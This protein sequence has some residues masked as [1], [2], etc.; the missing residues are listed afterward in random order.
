MGWTKREFITQAFEE[1]GLAA[2]V[3]DITPEQRWSALRR[4]DAMMAQWNAAGVRVGWG[5][6]SKP[7]M[8]DIDEQTNVTDSANEAI[9]TNLAIRLA[10]GFG[11]TISPDLKALAF[12]SYANL[13][14]HLANKIPQR[15]YPSSTPIGA[16]NKNLNAPFAMPTIDEL[17]AG[18]D[19]N[20]ILE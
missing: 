6:P 15:Q 10:S 11:K 14:S 9:Y 17:Q 8:S 12:T 16:G 18:D 5:L 4:L 20:I 3:Y 13:L 2:H 19:T 1:I 7:D